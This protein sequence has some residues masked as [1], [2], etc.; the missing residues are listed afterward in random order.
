MFEVVK[1]LKVILMPEAEEYLSKVELKI[2][3]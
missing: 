3:F 2:Q 1:P